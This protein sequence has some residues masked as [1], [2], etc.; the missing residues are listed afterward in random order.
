MPLSRRD[1]V[2]EDVGQVAPGIADEAD[3]GIVGS[4]AGFFSARND[5]ASWLASSSETSPSG[6]HVPVQ[7]VAV[8][9]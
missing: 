5:V 9:M 3:T 6:C 2:D 4:A 7:K 1:R 8:D